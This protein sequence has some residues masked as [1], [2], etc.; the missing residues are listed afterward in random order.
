MSFIKPL[1]F[2]SLIVY[3]LHGHSASIG[4]G[5]TFTE[6][7]LPQ[8]VGIPDFG[9]ETPHTGRLQVVLK[10]ALSGDTSR[11]LM[12]AAV[13]GQY[14]CNAGTYLEDEKWFGM[15]FKPDEKREVDRE[16]ARLRDNSNKYKASKVYA[17]SDDFKF[18]AGFASSQLEHGY[19]GEPVYW[20]LQEG[21]K[22]KSTFLPSPP[23]NLLYHSRTVVPQTISN[24]GLVIKGTNQFFI[25]PDD[26]LDFADQHGCISVDDFETLDMAEK[27]VRNELIVAARSKNQSEFITCIHQKEKEVY[28]EPNPAVFIWTRKS[29]ND[30]FEL[31][32]STRKNAPNLSNNY[33]NILGAT[34]G[35]EY[36]LIDAINID[37]AR[38]SF[39]MR[40]NATT[41]FFDI[42]QFANTT[43]PYGID[44]NGEVAWLKGFKGETL[45]TPLVN[46]ATGEGTTALAKNSPPK[47]DSGDTFGPYTYP[48]AITDF[49]LLPWLGD[50]A[51]P[52]QGAVYVK[53]NNVGEF[54]PS[55]DFFVNH[56]GVTEMS[57][58]EKSN[59]LQIYF[60]HA[61]GSKV[62]YYGNY[63][64][65]G[66]NSPDTIF[67]V[68]VDTTLCH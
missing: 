1:L 32:Y 8:G 5:H 42:V 12:N 3:G 51:K 2:G 35:G 44:Q 34:P 26:L 38:S 36:A 28:L 23:K 67:R 52:A 20:E 39:L 14:D 25:A 37:S 22:Y 33:A 66:F 53:T 58:W 61:Q 19:I 45:Q 43:R 57:H 7:L 18:A 17:I 55:L 54:V 65:T 30:P 29:I 15:V 11:I 21:G 16:V 62:T 50:N 68:T 24:D 56:C 31:N 40:Y 10:Q 41:N 27:Y 47:A 63:I 4:S 60:G 13:N 64:R 6:F 59:W 49:P 9:C 48:D 46:F